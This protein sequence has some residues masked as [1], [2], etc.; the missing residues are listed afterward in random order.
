MSQ[1]D[2]KLI[3]IIILKNITRRRTLTLAL[4]S[5]SHIEPRDRIHLSSVRTRRVDITRTLIGVLAIG[6][7]DIRDGQR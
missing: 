2:E 4:S 6:P 3:I 5:G 7:V 1:S